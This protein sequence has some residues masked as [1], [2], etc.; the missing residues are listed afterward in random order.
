[1]TIQ[2]YIKNEIKN[3]ENQHEKKGIKLLVHAGTPMAMGYQPEVDSY[4]ELNQDGID[5]FQELIS[6]SRWAVQ[7]GGVDVLT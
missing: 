7:I 5:T 1:M 4:P 3:L 6:I 2:K